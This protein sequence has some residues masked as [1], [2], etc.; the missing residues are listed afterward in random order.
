MSLNPPP[1]SIMSSQSHFTPT[2][3]T[4]LYGSPHN[5]H[6]NSPYTN[7][8]NSSPLKLKA[9]DEVFNQTF[10]PGPINMPSPA[11]SGGGAHVKLEE[12]SPY[13]VHNT[14]PYSSSG[15]GKYLIV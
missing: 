13:S 2:V 3:N 12:T 10:N 6:P 8:T 11:G 14:S 5:T 7:P 15:G 4:S 9:M 1:P